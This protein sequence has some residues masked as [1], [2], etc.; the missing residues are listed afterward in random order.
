M[1]AARGGPDRA[2]VGLLGSPEEHAAVFA[3]VVESALDAVIVADEAGVVVA[4]NPAAEATF[5]YTRDEAVGQ[6][7][8]TLIVPDN[9]RED[10]EAAC[11]AIG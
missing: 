3:A 7:I 11:R 5:G 8:A 6:S 1:T 10:H 2:T 4:I 9:H